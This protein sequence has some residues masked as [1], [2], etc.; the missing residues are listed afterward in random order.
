MSNRRE[1]PTRQ[2]GKHEI[3]ERV[4]GTRHFFFFCTNLKNSLGM[5]ECDGPLFVEEGVL[6]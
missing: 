3:R 1:L 5:K 4:E 2:W 6:R